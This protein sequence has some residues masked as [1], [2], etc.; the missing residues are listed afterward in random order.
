[1]AGVLAVGLAEGPVEHPITC[2]NSRVLICGSIIKREHLL[3][4]WDGLSSSRKQLLV[5]YPGFLT[6]TE[7]MN[8]QCSTRSYR[9]ASNA[10]MIRDSI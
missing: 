2:P 4:V 5:I 9:K 1:M 3:E 10:T 7:P 6:A 8:A